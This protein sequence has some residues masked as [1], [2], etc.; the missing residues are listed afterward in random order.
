M[1]C[2]DLDIDDI[3]IQN[4]SQLNQ[5][6]KLT[7]TYYLKN[8]E[9]VYD[10][11][12]KNDKSAIFEVVPGVTYTLI[13]LMILSFLSLIFFY[14]FCVG[15]CKLTIYEKNKKLFFIAGI[16]LLT[17]FLILLIILVVS[18]GQTDEELNK[19]K[20]FLYQVAED[21]VEG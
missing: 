17:V 1:N 15:K 21:F 18:I 8:F 19:S 3:F 20:C 5:L 12:T 11:H 4:K 13:I 16:I 9:Y 7:E 2:K 14:F 6:R 10:F